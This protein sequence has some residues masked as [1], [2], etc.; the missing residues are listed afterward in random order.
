MATDRNEEQSRQSQSLPVVV[1]WPGRFPDAQAAD[2]GI[3][4]QKFAEDTGFDLQVIDN[5]GAYRSAQRALDS[6]FRTPGTNPVPVTKEQAEA[7]QR[8]GTRRRDEAR[9]GQYKHW[10][11]HMIKIIEDRRDNQNINL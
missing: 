11:Q 9:R 6:Y 10:M 3:A 4:V 1:L 7:Q 8:L 2:I 5:Y